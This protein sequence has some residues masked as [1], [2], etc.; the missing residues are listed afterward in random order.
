MPRVTSTT[1]M[2]T[3]QAP[4]VP[5]TRL[6]L[7]TL[8][9]VPEAGI[10]LSLLRWREAQ[11]WWSARWSR[12]EEFAEAQVFE[13][14]CSLDC[15]W[16]MWWAHVGTCM[17]RCPPHPVHAKAPY[18]GDETKSDCSYQKVDASIG[19]SEWIVAFTE[20]SF[21]R[22]C[23]NLFSAGFLQ[24]LLVATQVQT[25][26]AFRLQAACAMCA[27]VLRRMQLGRAP[28]IWDVQHPAAVATVATVA[29]VAVDSVQRFHTN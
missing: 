18:Q 11:V 6:E 28:Q 26:S 17:L 12:S 15:C 4:A 10:G 25:S 20:S 1:R 7:F 27:C 29:T 2:L 13:T 22:T 14:S 8:F 16:R 19:G 9:T 23:S 5:A 24:Q 3:S 21:T